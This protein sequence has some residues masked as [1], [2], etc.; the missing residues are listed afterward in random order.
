ML[1]GKRPRAN[2][3]DNFIADGED[4]EEEEEEE[5]MLE[6]AHAESSVVHSLHTGDL[7][8]PGAGG[9]SSLLSTASANKRSFGIDDIVI[10]YHMAITT[11]VEKL[12]YKE[13]D[14]PRLVY[15]S[16]HLRCALRFIACE[17]KSLEMLTRVQLRIA[18]ILKVFFFTNKFVVIDNLC[19][20]V[21]SWSFILR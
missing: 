21:C 17:T 2:S 15:I 20:N 4:E 18:F 12:Q 16:T 14:T 8:R 11:R 13:I 10:P 6:R 9:S 19:F 1:I 3:L 5:E 7:H